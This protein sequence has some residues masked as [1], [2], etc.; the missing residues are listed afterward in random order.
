MLENDFEALI[1]KINCCVATI[2]GMA[3]DQVNMVKRHYGVV[4]Y[5][6]YY[7]V[8]KMAKCSMVHCST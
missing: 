4:Q 7:V 5:V 8:Y 2:E 3:S 6:H 1:L